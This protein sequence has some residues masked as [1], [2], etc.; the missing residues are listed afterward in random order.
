MLYKLLF[1]EKRINTEKAE[2]KGG[3]RITLDR[4]PNGACR[5]TAQ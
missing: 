2:G 3:E 5:R 4:K 1:P